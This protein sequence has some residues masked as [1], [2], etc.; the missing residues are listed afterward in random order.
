MSLFEHLE[1][2]SLVPEPGYDLNQPDSQPIGLFQLWPYPEL[3]SSPG[4]EFDVE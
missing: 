1:P 4:F 2:A 3:M